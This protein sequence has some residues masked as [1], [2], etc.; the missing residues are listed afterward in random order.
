MTAP[1]VAAIVAE[2]RRQQLLT[3]AHATVFPAAPQDLVEAGGSRLLHHRVLEGLEGLAELVDGRDVVVDQAIDEAVEEAEGGPR[4]GGRGA[5][6]PVEAGDRAKGN[7]DA[8]R[9]SPAGGG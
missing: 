8:A 6:V 5:D 1:L 2:S 3:T 9:K 7:S 4:P